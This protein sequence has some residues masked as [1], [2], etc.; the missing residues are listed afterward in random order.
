MWNALARV[1]QVPSDTAATLSSDAR[2]IAATNLAIATECRALLQAFED[3][4]VPLLFVKG[5]SVGALAYRSPLLKMGWDID[6]LIDP[7][8]LRQ[9]CDILHSLAYT[10]R[11]PTE[12]ADLSTWH[13]HSKESVWRRGHSFHVELHTRLADNAQLIPTIDV[14]SRRQLVEIA[15]SISLPTLADEE[16]LAYLAVH[17]SSSGWFRLKWIADFAALLA[18]R[19]VEELAQLYDGSQQLGAARAFGQALLVA[20][21]LFDVLTPNPGLCK[22]LTGDR[23]TSTLYRQAMAMMTNGYSEPTDRLMGT[24][25]I[26][27]TQFLL[28][29][30]PSFKLTELWRQLGALRLGH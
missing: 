28:R 23:A 9:A 5:L 15:P 2:S 18:G 29:P 22:R 30:G 4:R 13:K 6:L 24:L 17:G 10:H 12:G 7:L 3:A 27:W 19:G 16:L 1:E 26:H 8:D 25:T 20:N 11:I 21:E 14:R